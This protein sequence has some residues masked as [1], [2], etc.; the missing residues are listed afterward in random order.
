M[1]M[2]MQMSENKHFRLKHLTIYYLPSAIF[3]SFL[4]GAIFFIFP[5]SL[6]ITVTINIMLLYVYNMNYF[7]L[8]LCVILII[9]TVFTNQIVIKTLKNYGDRSTEFDYH[10][11][12]WIL[13]AITGGIIIITFSIITYFV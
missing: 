12:Y 2:V 9:L 10:K 1:K 11:L 13:T 6:L 4:T 7:L 5:A 3:K 8:G